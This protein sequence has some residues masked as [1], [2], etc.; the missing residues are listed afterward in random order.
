MLLQKQVKQQQQK[1]PHRPES[2]RYIVY[3]AS[4]GIPIGSG[5][6]QNS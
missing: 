4:I 1:T 3:T 6:T 2:I 5:Y